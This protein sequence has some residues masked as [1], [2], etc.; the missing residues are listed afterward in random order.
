MPRLQ[1]GVAP[2]AAAT[3]VAGPSS[4]AP[5]RNGKAPAA[6]NGKAPAARNGK[7]PAARNGKAPAAR[8]GKAPAARNGKAPA[9]GK[10][11]RAAEP[12]AV[13]LAGSSDWEDSSDSV[14]MQQAIF[15]STMPASPRNFRGARRSTAA[16]SINYCYDPLREAGD[17]DELS[18]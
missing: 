14:E 3:A 13:D 17:I 2:P 9:C 6:R 1:A 15:E 11:P 18:D 16:R 10:R 4:P 12:T 5:A 7:A 8:N